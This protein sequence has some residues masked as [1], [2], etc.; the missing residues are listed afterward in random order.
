LFFIL[1]TKISYLTEVYSRECLE[2][3]FGQ[4]ITELSLF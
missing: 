1:S 3:Y 2:R 4:W